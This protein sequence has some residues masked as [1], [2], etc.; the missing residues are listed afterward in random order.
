MKLRQRK[1][2]MVSEEKYYLQCI[3]RKG[4][5]GVSHCGAV[6]WESDCSGLGHCECAG[7]IPGLA[8][9][10]KGSSV[11]AA[12]QIQFLAQEH[13]YAV[14]VAINNNNNNNQPTK[15]LKKPNQNYTWILE[16]TLVLSTVRWVYMTWV[17]EREIN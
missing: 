10:I 5:R 15:L 1:G 4:K 12:A 2:D 9:W 8:Q 3:I 14:G 7:S 6:G 16:L 13:P 17:I 11:T